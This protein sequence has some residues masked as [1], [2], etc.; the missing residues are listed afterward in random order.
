[1]SFS[2]P[3]IVRLAERLL[4]DIE[5]AVR[6]FHRY[7][8]YALGA[9]LRAAAR[10]VA[11]LA[12]RAWRDRARIGEWTGK[13]VWAIDDLKLELQ[14]GQRIKAFRSFAQFE[15]L[16]RLCADLGRQAGGWHRQ[17]CPNGQ[18]RTAQP[19]PRERAEILSTRNASR[20]EANA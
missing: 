10:T 20:S 4:A 14:T 3:P 5:Q 1:M 19:A 12:H 8:K 2:L 6:Q 17:Q 13:L 18:N 16:A 7:H 11:K 15:A 9:D